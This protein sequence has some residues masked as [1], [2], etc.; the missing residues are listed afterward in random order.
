[1]LSLATHTPGISVEI[2]SDQPGRR[3][4]TARA[5][6]EDAGRPAKVPRPTQQIV[7]RCHPP[8]TVADG[9]AVAGSTPAAGASRPLRVRPRAQRRDPMHVHPPYRAA[10]RCRTT[11]AGSR[12]PGRV[13]APV[14]TT[15][16]SL[17]APRAVPS[18]CSRDA[19]SSRCLFAYGRCA[20]L[21]SPFSRRAVVRV[22]HP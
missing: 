9:M 6:A 13:A 16:W 3:H 11:E 2:D 5:C 19:P 17:Y 1:M 10:P 22:F 21:G 20:V 7:A 12:W 15:A 18:S 4:P 14:A 8:L